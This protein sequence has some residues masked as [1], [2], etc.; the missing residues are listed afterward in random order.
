MPAGTDGL[1]FAGLTTSP[2]RE[3]V[4]ERLDPDLDRVDLPCVG[5]WAIATAIAK[6]VDPTK[7]Y[8]SDLSLFSTV[9]GYLADPEKSLADLDLTI[10]ERVAAF[11]PD[12]GDDIRTASGILLATKYL[13]LSGAKAYNAAFRREVWV[14]RES[15]RASIEEGLREQI[16][17]LGGVHY[18]NE[19]V[20]RVVAEF[21]DRGNEGDA[22]YVN[23]PGYAGGYT[24]MYGE[25]ERQLWTCRLEVN[26]FHP[27]EALPLLE[28][29]NDTP[30]Q[31]FAYIHHGDDTMPESW[32]KQLAVAIGGGRTDYV[33]T[34]QDRD[35]ARL[36]VGVK[37]DKPP[38]RFPI[39]ANQEIRPDSV[40]EFRDV[41]KDT[42]LYYRDLFVHRLGTAKAERFGLM[43][44]DGRVTTAFGLMFR[45]LL[46][47]ADQYIAEV[48]G[49]STTS[50]RYAR[51]GKLFMLALTSG[52]FKRW[53]ARTWPTQIGHA[54]PLGIKTAS[55]TINHEGKTD[56]GVLEL[57][58]REPR[59]GGGFQLLYQG[60]FRD[61][62]F[63]EVLARW[64]ATQG[65]IT[66]PGYTP[67]TQEKTD[68][69]K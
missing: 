14:N 47:G 55:P 3:F 37:Y 31:A 26:E 13:M 12:G 5:R 57:V 23:L 6:K 24:K 68:A 61:D 50:D 22:I 32:T 60:P 48:F 51:L 58:R 52:E 41:D 63:E 30:G 40:I 19:D 65:H 45:D 43:L 49:I 53:A 10:P 42:C 15:I 36:A 18:E 16:D 46:R 34:N 33:V 64:L 44:I 38:R 2:A 39:F 1:L 4:A 11:V 28:S 17:V 66:R 56:R 9:I 67:K 27:D 59:P 20:R 54:N 7:I 69:E 8:A 25:A 35:G 21:I 62:T 29:L